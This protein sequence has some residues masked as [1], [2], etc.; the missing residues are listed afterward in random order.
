[1]NS[2]KNATYIVL[3]GMAVTVL[4]IMGRSDRGDEDE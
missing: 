3:I 1:M 2:Y 4:I